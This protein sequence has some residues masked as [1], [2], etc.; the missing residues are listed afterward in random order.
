MNYRQLGST[1]IRVS[2]VGFGAW[3]LGN[4]RD[5]EG[6]EDNHAIKLVHEAL[7]QA[8]ISLIPPLIMEGVKVNHCLEKLLLEEGARR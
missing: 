2:E 8:A 7:D 6:M 4:A 1:G 3:Q 5:W